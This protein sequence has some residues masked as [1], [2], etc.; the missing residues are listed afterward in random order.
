MPAKFSILTVAAMPLIPV[1]LACT[2]DDGGH[3]ISVQPDAAA[4]QPDAPVNCTAAESY[5]G[6]LTGSAAPQ[7]GTNYPA[8][9]SGSD[10]SV[11]RIVGTA[12]LSPEVP[13]DVLF[14]DLY[15]NYGVFAGGDIKTGTFYLNGDETSY[16]S[17]GA[18][19][20]IAADVTQ[21]AITDWY[22]A[23]GGQV[24]ITAVSGTNITGSLKDV[25]FR[26]VKT[27]TDGG[28]TDDATGDCANVKIPTG[29]FNIM[30]SPPQMMREVNADA[31][32][33]PRVL[34]HRMAQ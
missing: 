1:A 24:D 26:R 15:A 12:R 32:E 6:L 2:G 10:A 31:F 34:T 16:S 11:H 8:A 29:D 20:L 30:L 22:M 14:M 25:T 19:V 28:P 4:T 7:R 9:G 21:N 23:S 33:R 13:P 27:G 18:C 3:H 5:A 17:C